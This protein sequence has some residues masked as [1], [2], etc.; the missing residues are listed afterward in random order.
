MMQIDYG[1][2][3]GVDQRMVESG[4]FTK[5]SEYT[6]TL[7][8]YLPADGEDGGVR[9]VTRN[10]VYDIWDRSELTEEL[11]HEILGISPPEMFRRAGVECGCN[12]L[13]YG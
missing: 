3:A 13:H 8:R 1:N 11:V 4:S 9:V 12:E 2:G 7:R 6:E 5:A 10:G